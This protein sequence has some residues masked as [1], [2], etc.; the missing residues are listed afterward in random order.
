MAEVIRRALAVYDLV[1]TAKER[2]KT[3][4]FR[5]ARDGEEERVVI[6]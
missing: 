5:E 2:G 3:L 4:F 6:I 1:W